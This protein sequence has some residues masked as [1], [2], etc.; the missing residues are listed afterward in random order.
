VA[1]RNGHF[2]AARYNAEWLMEKNGYI[3]PLDVRITRLDTSLRCA[4]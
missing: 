4:A 3:S 2:L 1:S